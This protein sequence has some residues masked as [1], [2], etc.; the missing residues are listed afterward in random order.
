MNP[1]SPFPRVHCGEAVLISRSSKGNTHLNGDY[2]SSSTK[3]EAKE[4]TYFI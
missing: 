4:I 3:V 1:T 2:V